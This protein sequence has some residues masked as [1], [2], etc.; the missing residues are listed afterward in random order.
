VSYVDGLVDR[1]I[2]SGEEQG[3]LENTA[4]VI[5]ADHGESLGEHEVWY[6]HAGLHKETVHVPLILKIPG[7]PKGI[8]VSDI[9]STLDIAPTVL[10]FC[11]LEGIPG[12][13]GEDLVKIATKGGDP[14]R[15]VW[16]EYTDL[17]Q[18]GT[19]DSRHHFINTTKKHMSLGVFSVLNDEGKRIP[20]VHR[21]PL[22]TSFLYD[23]RKDP[24]LEKDISQENP[25]LVEAYRR[26][27]SNWYD[28]LI[29]G[30]VIKR[31]I[32]EEE[33]DRLRA[34]GYGTGK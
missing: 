12:L 31:T 24:S 4:I 22:G 17:F 15:R 10:S 8:R 25:K 27:I 16:F 9:V 29:Q 21:I 26:L 5:T 28:G 11:G 32:S 7:G 1:I 14:T 30:K 2:S 19:R 23:V 20:D 18:V 33:E 6:D 13:H 3:L 34:L